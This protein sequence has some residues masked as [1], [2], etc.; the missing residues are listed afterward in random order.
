MQEKHDST[1]ER[2]LKM[3]IKK[4][5]VNKTNPLSFF[6]PVMVK[7]DPKGDRYNMKPVPNQKVILEEIGALRNKFSDLDRI[8]TKCWQDYPNLGTGHFAAVPF[9][10]WGREHVMR[11]ADNIAL[12]NDLSIAG[13]RLEDRYVGI[14]SATE[15]NGRKKLLLLTRGVRSFLKYLSDIESHMKSTIELTDESI[16]NKNALAKANRLAYQSYE[17]AISKN[18][19]LAEA[20]DDKVYDWLKDYSS[21]EEYELPPNCETWK[22]QVRAGRKHHGRQRNTPRTGRSGRSIIQSGQV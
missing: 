1:A 2:N 15:E 6:L 12:D 18:S 7:T 19:K 11:L 21:L 16:N 22:R 20:T 9:L 13:S 8:L 4:M 5:S 14:I 17:H 3:I 10:A